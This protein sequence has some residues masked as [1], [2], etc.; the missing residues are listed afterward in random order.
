[1]N[2]ICLVQSICACVCHIQELKSEILPWI[3]LA[4]SNIHSQ[5]DGQSITQAE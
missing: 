4:V 2:P 1:M 3:N 5:L